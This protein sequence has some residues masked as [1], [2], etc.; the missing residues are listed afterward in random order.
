MDLD[1]VLNLLGAIETAMEFIDGQRDTMTDPDSDV[2]AQVPNRACHVYQELSDA[3]DEG[4]K[5]YDR[6]KED[7]YQRECSADY[8]RQ[9]RMQAQEDAQ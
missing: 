2:G 8:K 9:R 5:L 1:D 7:Q 3:Y 6:A 4:C